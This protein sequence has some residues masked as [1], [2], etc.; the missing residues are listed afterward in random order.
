MWRKLLISIVLV[1][2]IAG[3]MILWSGEQRPQRPVTAPHFVAAEGR[4]AVKPDHRAI[5][6][7]ELAGR[8][9]RM[10]VD[11]LSPVK[12]GQVLA[13]IYNADLERGIHETEELL[14]KAEA[15]YA[16][17]ANGSRREDI[18]EAHAEVQ[19]AE[20]ALELAR[21]NEARDRR[22]KDE[23][24]LAQSGY[25]ETAAEFK[26]ATSALQAAQERYHRVSNGERP[27]TV[28]A[29]R[30]Q[31]DSQRYALEALKARY[32]K[33]FVRSPLDGIVIL[34][35]RNVS[36]FA[37]V[38]NPIVEVADLSERIVEGDVNEMDAGAVSAGQQVI[39][40]SDAYPGIQYAARVYEVSASLKR[41]ATDPEDPAVVIDQ[42]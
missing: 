42:N 38:G 27:E 11:N 4:V 9:D 40:T 28:M 24:V 29:A 5:L 19:R 37:D 41:R 15:V 35:Y 17:A 25:D 32:E 30:A 26:Q 7:A 21:N 16:E 20:A 14:R 13:E 34:R 6:S 12:K 2:A 1:S 10:Y 3:A 22:L 31:R 23:G 33:T 18:E 8:I 36:E 39:V